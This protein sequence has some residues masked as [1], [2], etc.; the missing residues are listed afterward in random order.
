MN[1]STVIEENL[2]R[3]LL[4]FIDKKIAEIIKSSHSLEEMDMLGY[5][6]GAENLIG[7]GFVVCQTYMTTIRGALEIKSKNALS[8]PPMHQSGEMI[9]KIVNDL[10]NY[11]KH[12]EEW[13]LDKKRTGKKKSNPLL[14]K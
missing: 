2:A 11:W 8:Y 5:L 12:N 14:R 10:A 3:E 4:D 7:L 9:A 1:V 13:G 6:D